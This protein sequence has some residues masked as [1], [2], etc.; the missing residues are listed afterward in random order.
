MFLVNIL[1]VAGIGTH[2]NGSRHDATR[3]IEKPG[4]SPAEM[5]IASYAAMENNNKRGGSTAHGSKRISAS[6]LPEGDSDLELL[7]CE[8]VETSHAL[9][10]AKVL[11]HPFHRALSYS[12]LIAKAN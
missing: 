11:V 4:A 7:L 6:Q 5:L 12:C 2:K 9:S 1:A 3:S 10:A 8:M